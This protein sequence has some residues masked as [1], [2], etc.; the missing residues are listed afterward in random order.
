MTALKKFFGPPLGRLLAM[1]K[2]YN[3]RRG[4][5]YAASITFSGILALVPILMVTFA[6]TGVVL[7]SRPELVEQIIDAILRNVPGEMGHT[8]SDVI[9]SAINSRAAVGTLGL[10]GAA[11]TGIGWIGQVREGLTEMWGGRV[12][13][14]FLTSKL[15]DLGLFFGL[16]ALLLVTLLLGA[17]ASGP[18][19]HLLADHMTFASEGVRVFIVQ[20]GSRLV[21]VLATWALLTIVLS[22]LPLE[23]IPWSVVRSSALVCALIFEVLKEVGSVY[24]EKVLGGPAGIAFGPIIG[25]MVFAYLASRIL[26]YAAAWTASNPANEPFWI[27]DDQQEAASRRRE[28]A[29]EQIQPKEVVLAPVYETPTATASA[30]GLLTAAGLGALLGGLLGRSRRR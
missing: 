27:L 19:A 17:T 6:I 16:G 23:K 5:V 3:E 13:R 25:I 14:R 8:L 20:W 11:F 30:R 26:L 29:L 7:A 9:H 21:S 18:I 24:L 4:N 2:W 1:Q 10:A 28:K 12:K 22:Q 15:I